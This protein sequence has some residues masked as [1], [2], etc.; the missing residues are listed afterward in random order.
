MGYPS[1]D[2][3]VDVADSGVAA[4][5]LRQFVERIERLNEEIAGINSDKKDIFSEAKS[6]GFDTKAMKI[7]ITRRKQDADARQEQDAIVELYEQALSHPPAPRA[8]ARAKN[9]D[10]GSTMTMSYT[11]PDTGE[12]VTTPPFTTGDLEKVRKKMNLKG[13]LN[14]V[15][16]DDDIDPFG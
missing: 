6:R 10:D 1:N 3:P 11:N 13:P 4:D 14:P 15:E 9:R 12:K 8:P 5:E 7:I 16:D 2:A